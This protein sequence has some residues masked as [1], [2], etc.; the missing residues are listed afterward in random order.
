MI[1]NDDHWH[2]LASGNLPEGHPFLLQYAMELAS[3]RPDEQIPP[4]L[5]QYCKRNNF[6]GKDLDE[7]ATNGQLFDTN[8]IAKY[9]ASRDRS[10]KD[11]NRHLVLS[12]PEPETLNISKYPDFL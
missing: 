10:Y 11:L 7:T 1:K 12:S 5:L 4:R 6:F 9:V 2:L 3:L 8:E